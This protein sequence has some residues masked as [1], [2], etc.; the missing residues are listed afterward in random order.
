VSH[1]LNPILA[2]IDGALADDEFPDAMRWSPEPDTVD[3]APAAFDG[4]LVWQPL[5]RYEPVDLFAA[6]R[7][8]V[9]SA[10]EFEEAYR[11]LAVS[12]ADPASDPLGD[13]LRTAEL[14]RPGAGHAD[15]RCSIAPV[16]DG[17]LDELYL[18]DPAVRGEVEELRRREQ[19]LIAGQVGEAFRQ[20]A[21]SFG[22]AAQAIAPTLDQIGKALISLRSQGEPPPVEL[23]DTDPKAHALQVRRTRG[24]G[25]E[26]Q[27]QRQHRPRRIR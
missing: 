20:V 15:A 23:R 10:F 14:H 8:A 9:T 24:T 7:A 6:S 4:S 16:F 5:Q 25:P 17:V 27:L 1:D 26:R 12:W 2:A 11:H 22:S 13:V 18:V 21:E 3:D 19:T